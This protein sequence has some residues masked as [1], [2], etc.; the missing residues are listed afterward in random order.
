[1]KNS[2]KNYFYW[3]KLFLPVRFLPWKIP[4]F[5]TNWQ[6]LANTVRH[7]LL[8]AFRKQIS[9]IYHSSN[10]YRKVV[11]ITRHIWQALTSNSTLCNSIQWCII[12]M[13]FLLQ[14]IFLTSSLSQYSMIS[15]HKLLQEIV[16]KFCWL[17]LRLHESLYSMYGVPVSICAP[18]M[19]SHN[20]LAG[21]TLRPCPSLSY[22]HHHQTQDD[23]CSLH[24]HGPSIHYILKVVIYSI[25]T[26][27]SEL[28]RVSL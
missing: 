26:F 22:L 5:S 23:H 2:G 6:K 1:M 11:H 7:L 15:V 3:Q 27:G 18:M 25:W 20:F 16:P 12:G 28:I 10:Y 14:A 4:V 8:H 24:S 19:C 9:S 17:L 13:W 21:T